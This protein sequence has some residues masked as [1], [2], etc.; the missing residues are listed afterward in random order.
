MNNISIFVNIY[1]TLKTQRASPLRLTKVSHLPEG[2]RQ[3]HKTVYDMKIQLHRWL[4]VAVAWLGIT[5]ANAYDFEM[6]GIYYD[7]NS[8][9]TSVTV[10]NETGDSYAGS[11][12]GDVVIPS[13]VTHDG[14]NY[15]VT[16]IGDCAFRGCIDLT[17]VTIPESVTLIY[18]LPFQGC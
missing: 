1:I 11:Y 4:G 3:V 17:S 14:K 13:S 8:D 5:S 7:I 2:E 16:T 15:S 9:E 10:T 6:D 18:T 12:S